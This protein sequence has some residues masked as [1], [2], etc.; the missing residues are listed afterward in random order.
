MDMEAFWKAIQIHI[1]RPPSYWS[2][3]L[4]GEIGEFANWI[5]KLDRDK[6]DYDES[7][8]LEEHADIFIYW[9]C[10]AKRLGWTL[11]QV[12][13]EI[14]HKIVVVNDGFSKTDDIST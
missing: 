3:A 6:G 11:D 8:A 4:A 14:A 5:K 13:A 7:A 10:M 12:L 2:N 9:V 1:D